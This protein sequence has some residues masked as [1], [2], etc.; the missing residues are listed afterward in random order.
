[1]HDS[2]MIAGVGDIENVSGKRMATPLAPPSPGSTPIST[3]SVMPTNMSSRLI[4]VRMTLKPWKRA[5]SS[6]MSVPQ[7]FERLQPALVEGDLEPHLE[8]E[9]EE[10]RDGDAQQDAFHPGELAQDDHE[11]GDVHRR[12]EVD[13][14]HLDRQDVDRGRAQHGQH[15]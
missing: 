11:A 12:S 15:E 6:V 4:G 8:H 3:P 1:M 13:A 9:E 2:R 14:D 5:L 7:E 10:R